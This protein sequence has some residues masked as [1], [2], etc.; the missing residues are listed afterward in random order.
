MQLAIN[1]V[2]KLSWKMIMPVQNGMWNE[3]CINIP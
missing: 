3:Q 2:I 1:D